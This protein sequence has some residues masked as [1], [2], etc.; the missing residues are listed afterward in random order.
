MIG[1]KNHT[2]VKKEWKKLSC[3]HSHFMEVGGTLDLAVTST[4]MR[5]T[6][7]TAGTT[8]MGL[9]TLLDVLVNRVAEPLRKT[10]GDIFARYMAGDWSM[11]VYV[12]LNATV[13]PQIPH[14]SHNFHPPFSSTEDHIVREQDVLTS[15]ITVATQ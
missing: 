2:Y 15:E 7:P 12:N 13:H 3:R 4:K 14:L 6:P 8:V 5:K 9:Q 11:L 10:V 1:N